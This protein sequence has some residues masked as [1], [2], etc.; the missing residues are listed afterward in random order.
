MRIRKCL[1]G[2]LGI[3]LALGLGTVVI[4][5]ARADQKVPVRTAIFTAHDAAAVH[6]EPVHWRRGYYFGAYRGGYFRGAYYGRAFYRPYAYR[7]GYAY[8]RFYGYSYPRYWGYY[9]PGFAYN[10]YYSYYSPY[11]Y[12]APYTTVPMALTPYGH[13][14]PAAVVVAPAGGYYW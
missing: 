5:S 12:P 11:A 14:L 13:V 3:G 2:L 6:A 4:R 1:W 10:P 7:Y 8:P 9:A